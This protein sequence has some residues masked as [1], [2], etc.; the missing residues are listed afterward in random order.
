MQCLGK[1]ERVATI[2]HLENVHQ[3]NKCTAAAAAGA[4]MLSIVTPR[5]PTQHHEFIRA[6]ICT[7][8]G[9]RRQYGCIQ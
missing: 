4:E 7:W 9:I 8:R 6:F 2:S 1:Q 3:I 5:T